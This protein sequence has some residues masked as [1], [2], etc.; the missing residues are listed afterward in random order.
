MI[1]LKQTVVCP[2]CGEEHYFLEDFSDK[3]LYSNHA[4]LV[5]GCCGKECWWGT[6]LS[7]TETRR[8]YYGEYNFSKGMDVLFT[9]LETQ[10]A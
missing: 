7:L 4:A 5:C 9:E 3:H 1:P 8:G 2:L 10:F 6:V